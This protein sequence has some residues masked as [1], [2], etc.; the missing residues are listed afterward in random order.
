[1]EK[2]KNRKC[3]RLPEGTIK[4]IL[5][6][7]LVVIWYLLGASG[8]F[9]PLLMPSLKVIGKAFWTSLTRG[10]LWKDIVSSLSIVVKGFTIGASLGLVLGIFMGCFQKA[11]MFFAG[12]LNSLRQIPPLAWIPLL[13]LWYGITDISKVILL[14]LGSFFPVLLNATSGIKEV[15]AGY[16]EFAKNYKV[17]KKDILL[18]ILL[19]AASPS[20]FVGLRL[21][22]GTAWM[23]IVAAE[24]IA[25]TAGLGYRINDN[26]N[27]LRTDI[28]IAYMVVIGI[29]GGG[30]D[31]LIRLLGRKLT[32]WQKP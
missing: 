20:V 7:I 32:R 15:P 30:M 6:V 29:M 23:S 27:L 14:A 1:M 31:A 11:Y 25:A 13:I 9:S 4:F 10:I 2:P 8:K 21:G 28:V 26:R 19:P 24:M 17:R 12:T 22:A 5:P 18:K 3:L 16:M